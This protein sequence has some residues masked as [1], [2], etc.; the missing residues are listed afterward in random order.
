MRF[1]LLFAL[2]V[3]STGCPNYVPYLPDGGRARVNCTNNPLNVPITVLDRAQMPAPGAVVEVE[4]L[5]YGES[6]NLIA[7]AQGKAILKEKFG[8]GVVRLIANVNDLRSDVAEVTFTGTECS[9]AVTPRSLTMQ[10][11]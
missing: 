5:S 2:L 6:E 10:V 11:R 4:Y 8:P 9:S 1:A 7:D 3:V